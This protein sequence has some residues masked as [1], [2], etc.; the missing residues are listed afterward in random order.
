MLRPSKRDIAPTILAGEGGTTLY[1]SS[2]DYAL[3]ASKTFAGY[4]RAGDTA[5]GV[6]DGSGHG[7]NR[8]QHAIRTDFIGH[9]YYADSDSVIGDLRDLIM[10]G[11]PSG[12][13]RTALAGHDR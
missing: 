5:D 7:H 8:R 2:G 9:S 12:E 1:A 3:M 4:P 10:K 11:K 13:A 6:T